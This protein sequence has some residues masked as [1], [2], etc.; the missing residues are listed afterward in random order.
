MCAQVSMHV[1]VCVF[2]NMHFLALLTT[3]QMQGHRQQM[4]LFPK[5]PFPEWSQTA[6]GGA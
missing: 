6:V 3:A 2:T 1:C 5:A 4:S